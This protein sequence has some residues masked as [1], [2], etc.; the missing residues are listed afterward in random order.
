M[1][2][3]LIAAFFVATSP[4]FCQFVAN[5]LEPSRRVAQFQVQD[6][7]MIDALLKLGHQ[8]EF[9]VGIDYIDA[10]AFEKKLS[11]SVRDSTVASVL[12]QITR[13]LGY[14]WSVQGHAINVTH[15]GVMLGRRNVLNTR[16]RHFKVGPMPIEQA[17]C[18]LAI[19]F[20]F[21]LNPKMQGLAGDCPFGG[22]DQRID[23]LQMNNS[24]VRE[25]LNALVSQHG[26]G[27]WV[28]QQ[29]SWTLNKDLGFG[30]WKL[31]AYDRAD[32]RYSRM[33]LVRGL[34]L[35]KP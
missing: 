19:A 30:V 9:G 16:I 35:T 4:M 31:L 23:G 22:S 14:M 18:Q 2:L 15:P 12:D 11:I 28:V 29:P 34:G 10:A 3:A 13:A 27:A 21:A 7:N 25:I 24:T 32:G 33:L 20:K 26:N 5:G 1:R 17:G 8:E 6:Q